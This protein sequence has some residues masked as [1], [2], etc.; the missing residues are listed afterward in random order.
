MQQEDRYQWMPCFKRA[1]IKRRMS[2]IEKYHS[3]GADMANLKRLED[4]FLKGELNGLDVLDAL[5]CY[6]HRCLSS[7]NLLGKEV[8][9]P[10]LY[11]ERDLRLTILDKDGKTVSSYSAF[12]FQQVSSSKNEKSLFFLL[13]RLCSRV[14]VNN[15][16]LGIS[17]D[18]D[19]LIV[20]P[21]CVGIIPCRSSS[22]LFHWSYRRREADQ[23][24]MQC[25]PAVQYFIRHVLYS[26]FQ[27]R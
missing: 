10:C 9:D 12:P 5:G 7:R 11:K 19:V 25:A 3:A 13:P 16:F 14:Q 8:G 15:L 17:R 21:N 24:S 23:V 22:R 4:S 6:K 1:L 20:S 27:E 18:I 2:C 26:E